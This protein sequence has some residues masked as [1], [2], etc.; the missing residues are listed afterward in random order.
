MATLAMVLAGE[1]RPGFE[2][3]LYISRG[4]LAESNAQFVRK[5]AQMAGMLGRELARPPEAREIL[6]IG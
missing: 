1:V 3:N 4:V 5:G 6:G 2:D